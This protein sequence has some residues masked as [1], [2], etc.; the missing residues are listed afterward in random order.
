[1]GA[2]KGNRYAA[3]NPGGG[4][5][6]EY[7][8]AYIRIA[9]KMCELGA[10]DVEIAD[11]LD[12]SVQTLY[13]WKLKHKEF[14]L[15]LKVSKTIADERVERS[16]YMRAMG[17]TYDS[18]HFSSFQG[19]VTETP[20]R[21]HVPPDPTSMIFWL[22]NRQPEKWRDRQNL[23]HTGKD[24]GPIETR[25]VE[26]SPEREAEILRQLN[27]RMPA[28]DNGTPLSSNGHNGNGVH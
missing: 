25:N 20:Y 13:H 5:P 4:R 22:K 6:T 2:P 1:M 8:R 17:Y 9:K 12:I 27:H 10:T 11:A 7:R 23:E 14:C 16:L 24:G 18:I 3:G 21:E 15:A 28:L 19:L 26:V